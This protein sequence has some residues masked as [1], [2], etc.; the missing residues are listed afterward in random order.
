VSHVR[1]TGS[2]ATFGIG[3]VAAVA[4]EPHRFSAAGVDFGIIV[5]VAAVAS[6]PEANADAHLGEDGPRGATTSP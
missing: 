3:C 4:P 1:T 5:D 2:G 6:V